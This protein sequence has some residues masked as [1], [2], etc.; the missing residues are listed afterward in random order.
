[1]A[2]SS[3]FKVR[4]SPWLVTC[5]EHATCVADSVCAVH[6][7]TMPSEAKRRGVGFWIKVTT[8]SLA[9]IASLI[10]LKQ[11]TPHLVNQKLVSEWLS[12][13]G[14]WAP[15]AF[16]LFLGVRPV[17]LLP[18]QLLTAVGGLM[19]GAL[20]GSVYSLAGSALALA[21][22]F[23]LG[24]RFGKRLMKRLAGDK[25]QTLVRVTSGREFPFA[26]LATIN[27][28][29]PTDVIVAAMAASKARFW[30][31]LAGV[32]VGTLPGTFLT[33]QFGSALGQGKTITTAV[34]GAGMVISLVVGAWLGR[35]VLKEISEA[36][37][38]PQPERRRAPP[39]AMGSRATV[40]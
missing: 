11:L 32:L 6:L 4:P 26:V 33:A 21:L 7:Q 24:Q 2:P 19:F 8:P 10:A 14:D 17:T 35:K 25:Y 13:L 39:L 28:L 38:Q 37:R 16:V 31:T 34:A 18:G 12:Q 9:A 1:M 30:P 29:M 27:P 23:T 36:D 20:W 22:L 40:P 5:S 3:Q 15:L